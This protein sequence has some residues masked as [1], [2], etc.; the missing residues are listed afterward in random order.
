MAL[1]ERQ[2]GN[3]GLGHL[4]S[5]RYATAHCAARA[6]YHV[7]HCSVLAIVDVRTCRLLT[8]GTVTRY[9]RCV[10]RGREAAFLGYFYAA[11]LHGARPYC[12]FESSSLARGGA[13]QIA[14]LRAEA[15]GVV[16]VLGL[17]LAFL[18]RSCT[19]RPSVSDMLIG[20]CFIQVGVCSFRF[21]HFKRG[22]PPNSSLT[23]SSPVVGCRR[24]CAN[25]TL[26]LHLRDLC[27]D[28]E[29]EMLRPISWY[30]RLVRFCVFSQAAL[31]S[32]CACSVWRWT[33]LVYFR[34]AL[35]RFWGL[36]RQGL[37]QN[38]VAKM[39]VP[40]ESE[41]LAL[42]MWNSI[43]TSSSYPALTCLVSCSPEG[44]EKLY[45]FGDGFTIFSYSARLVRTVD[46]RSCVSAGFLQSNCSHF[47]REDGA[48]ILR[49]ISKKDVYF[50]R[51]TCSSLFDLWSTGSRTVPGDDFPRRFHYSSFAWL[52]SGY[53]LIRQSMEV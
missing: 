24:H 50:E 40:V 49:S 26:W 47:L 15:V 38:V 41:R 27:A 25:P 9:I 34:Q 46:T 8:T 19:Y 48:R 4:H 11:W 42:G 2:P 29:Q 31:L 23:V 1:R 14:H 43:A 22:M 17:F 37:P 5:P 53:T 32:C 52:D 33:A 45:L 28:T 44:Y 21:S 18:G 39:S 6:N 10:R 20:W 36:C 30:S 35:F 51:V 13:S 12:L 16:S 3:G 7:P